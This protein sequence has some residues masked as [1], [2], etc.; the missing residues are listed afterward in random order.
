M[1]SFASGT[2]LD[3]VHSTTSLT[4]TFNGIVN[5]GFYAFGGETFQAEYTGTDFELVAV[6][7]PAT[8]LAGGLTLLAGAA[9]R[10]R[11]RRLR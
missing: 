6:P 7:E 3:L 9:A 2:T 4:G 10:R 1:R 8:W 11:S 5:G